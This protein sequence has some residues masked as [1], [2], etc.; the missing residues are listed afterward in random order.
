MKEQILPDV[1]LT[2]SIFF[3]FSSCEHKIV[4]RNTQLTR[5]KWFIRAG[6]K[7]EKEK[8]RSCELAFRDLHPVINPAVAMTTD[9]HVC[10]YCLP[11]PELSV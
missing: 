10:A 5:K 2:T 1:L 8:R 6:K 9:Q 3:F 7:K 4:T 11:K